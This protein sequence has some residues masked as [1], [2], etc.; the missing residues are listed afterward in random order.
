MFPTRFTE[1]FG[2]QYT[3]APRG[4]MWVGRAPLA[5]AA[6]EAGIPGI[7]GVLTALTRELTSKPS[8]PDTVMA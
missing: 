7:P 6:S 8:E 2:A 3:I 5:A 4:M 1:Q